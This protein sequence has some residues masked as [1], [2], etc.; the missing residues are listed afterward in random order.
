[1]LGM[2]LGVGETSTFSNALLTSTNSLK[3]RSIRLPLKFVAESFGLAATKTGG[4]LSLGPPPG[5]IILAQP[6]RLVITIA[7]K[8]N[9]ERE[10]KPATFIFI[11][12]LFTANLTAIIY[13]T[14]AF[15]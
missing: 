9:I 2:V 5:G 4:M 6:E 11:T 15:E 12:E 3:V 13:Y 7:L 1:M 14:I 10:K 8:R